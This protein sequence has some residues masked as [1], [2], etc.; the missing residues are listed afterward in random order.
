MDTTGKPIDV[1][2]NLIQMNNDRIAGFKMVEKD[3]N[4]TSAD[5]KAL[6]LKF[7]RQSKGN[8]TEL[9]T[10]V[11]QLGGQPTQGSDVQSSFHRA[12]IEVRETLSGDKRTGMLKE[13]ERGESSIKDCYSD[14]LE[15]GNGLSADMIA[16]ISKQKAGIDAAY[17]EIKVLVDE[18]G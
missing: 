13:C 10:L 12:W 9:T 1:L 2:N 4:E 18:L 16:V 17:N 11:T 5:L 8:V 3:L 15:Q 7:A 6:F 14:A